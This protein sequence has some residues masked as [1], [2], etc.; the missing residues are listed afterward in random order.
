M[1][2]STHSFNP[3]TPLQTHATARIDKSTAYFNSRSASLAMSLIM[4]HSKV[5]VMLCDPARRVWSDLNQWYWKVQLDKEHGDARRYLEFHSCPLMQASF[6][7][8]VLAQLSEIEA[9][10]N[11]TSFPLACPMTK[12]FRTCSLCAYLRGS[13][14]VDHAKAW[15]AAYQD[16]ILFLNSDNLRN[17]PEVCA[18]IVCGLRWACCA[19]ESDPQPCQ[20]TVAKVLDFLGWRR[21]LYPPFRNLGEVNSHHQKDKKY[22][23]ACPEEARQRLQHFFGPSVKRLARLLHQDFSAWL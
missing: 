11:S 1:Q 10:V 19:V 3:L 17:N 4:P 8:H 9:L 12:N 18:C 6:P 22:V 21:S 2:I 13:Y 14:Y 23:I 16:N 7:E 15:R 5:I 20:V